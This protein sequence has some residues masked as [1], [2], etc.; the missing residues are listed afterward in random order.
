MA[1]YLIL[2]RNFGVVLI[3][4]IVNNSFFRMKISKLRKIRYFSMTVSKWRSRDSKLDSCN[5]CPFHCPHIV[6]RNAQKYK[7]AFAFQALTM[8]LINEQILLCLLILILFLMKE[9]ILRITSKLFL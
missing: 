7:M 9:K 6:Q 8:Y 2:R 3:I 5:S 4:I 1:S